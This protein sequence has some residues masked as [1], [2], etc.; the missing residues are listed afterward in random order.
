MRLVERGGAGKDSAKKPPRPCRITAL[1][2]IPFKVKILSQI[3]TDAPLFKILRQFTHF[4]TLATTAQ[5]ES[6]IRVT[7]ILRFIAGNRHL[8]AVKRRADDV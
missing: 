7:P 8:S 4:F 1:Y 6:E 2:P 5:S 3:T